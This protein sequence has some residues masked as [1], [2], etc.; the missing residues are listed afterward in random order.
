VTSVVDPPDLGARLVF[1]DRP[2]WTCGYVRVARPPDLPAWWKID[3]C[4][5]RW[6]TDSSSESVLV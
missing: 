6:E 5:V 2:G 1:E 4:R 3:E